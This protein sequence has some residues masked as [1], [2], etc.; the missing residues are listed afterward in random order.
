[1]LAHA[2]ETALR[3]LH[4]FMPFVTEELWQT[5]KDRT[6]A[7]SWPASILEARYPERRPV[8]E[9]AERASARCSASSRPSE[10]SAAR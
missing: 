5:L 6:G 8:D 9:A 2:L 4:P 10:T 1:M 3:L 7:T